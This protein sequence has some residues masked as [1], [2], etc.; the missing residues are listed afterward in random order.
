MLARSRWHAANLAYAILGTALS[1][2]AGGCG[3]PVPVASPPSPTRPAV[4]VQVDWAAP[5]SVLIRGPHADRHLSEITTVQ[6]FLLWSRGD[7][8]RLE[9]LRLVR[10]GSRLQRVEAG[11]Q[12]AVVL[13]PGVTV[14]ERVRERPREG[15]EI[16]PRPPTPA[17]WGKAGLTVAAVAAIGGLVYIGLRELVDA[18]LGGA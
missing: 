18:M 16:P 4:I 17:D 14:S 13:G 9:V 12:L 2:A 3:G 1:L 7:T 10:S 11:S 15:A 6:G 5:Q 8:L